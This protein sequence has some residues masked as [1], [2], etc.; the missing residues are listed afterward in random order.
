MTEDVF[1]SHI[2]NKYIDLISRFINKDDS[3][4]ILS[5]SL[6]N[7]VIDFMVKNNYKFILTEKQF[8]GREL[9]AIVDLL[10]SKSCN[11]V[12]IGAYNFENETGSTFSKYIG[13]I[14]PVNVKK[15]CIDLDRI[16]G[17]ETEC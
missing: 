12:F 17:P 1:K 9:N 6:S 2:K 16:T 11:N 14:L 10:V 5:Y 7:M 15:I 4:I 13:T 3:T 8:N